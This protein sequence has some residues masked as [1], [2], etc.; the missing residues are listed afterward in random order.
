MGGRTISLAIYHAR[1]IQPSG[2]FVAIWIILIMPMVTS[3]FTNNSRGYFLTDGMFFLWTAFRCVFAPM[4]FVFTEEA[5]AKQPAGVSGMALPLTRAIDKRSLFRARILLVAAILAFP[6][7]MML[8][9][10]FGDPDLN[11]RTPIRTLKPIE[12]LRGEV[13]RD[14][15]LVKQQ[16]Q[17]MYLDRL[18]Q[19]SLRHLM[20]AEQKRQLYRIPNYAHVSRRGVLHIENGHRDKMLAATSLSLAGTSIMILWG[21]LCTARFPGQKGIYV[22][23]FSILVVFLIY[24]FGGEIFYTDANPLFERALIEFMRAPWT[25]V[26]LASVLTCASLFVAERLWLRKEVV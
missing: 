15:G 9:L 14:H 2:W 1:L 21:L 13:E 25:G 8:T 4:W 20:T 26:A 6:C 3:S 11:L 19:A 7:T 16:R 10:G 17:L 5:F 12:T 23:I 24:Q 18:P 22:A